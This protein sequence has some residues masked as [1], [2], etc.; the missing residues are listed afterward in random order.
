MK[1]NLAGLYI[2]PEAKKR[3]IRENVVNNV[4]KWAT[5]YVARALLP[6]K[7]N[8]EGERFARSDLDRARHC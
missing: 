2:Q 1:S 5:G 7:S 4:P 6:A 8:L 3:R